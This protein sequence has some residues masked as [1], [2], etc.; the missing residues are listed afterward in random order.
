MPKAEITVT[1]KKTE[2][3]QIMLDMKEDIFELLELVP[4]H[5]NIEK[6]RI[7]DSLTSKWK[8]MVDLVETEG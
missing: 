1:I 5:Q 6:E 2:A 3:F 8:R 4:D 7:A